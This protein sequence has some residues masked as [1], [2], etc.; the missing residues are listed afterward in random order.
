MKVSEKILSRLIH[1]YHVVQP[2]HRVILLVEV[3]E[4]V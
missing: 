4:R 2:K 3:H 1:P